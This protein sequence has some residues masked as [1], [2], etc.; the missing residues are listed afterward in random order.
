[1]GD[2]PGLMSES[3][4]RG[5]G[6]APDFAGDYRKY[7]NAGPPRVPSDYEA[8][9]TIAGKAGRRRFKW[10]GKDD[11]AC[12]ADTYTNFPYRSGNEI[13]FYPKMLKCNAEQRRYRVIHELMHIILDPLFTIC[14]QVMVKEQFV[15]WKNAKDVLELVDDHLAAIVADLTA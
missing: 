3:E 14:H 9:R 8:P 11:K 2:S 5:Y 10:N 6:D 7:G 15:T 1:M 4:A 12:A 13:N